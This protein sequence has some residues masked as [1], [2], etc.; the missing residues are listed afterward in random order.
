MGKKEEALKCFN[1]AIEV[2]KNLIRTHLAKGMILE[3]MGRKEDALESFKQYLKIDTPPSMSLKNPRHLKNTK[4]VL[5]RKA[6]LLFE[7]KRWMEA[8]VAFEELKRIHQEKWVDEKEAEA[9]SKLEEE[10]NEKRKAFLGVLKKSRK[11]FFV[12]RNIT[13]PPE[14]RWEI[15]MGGEECEGECVLSLEEKKKAVTFGSNWET[16]GKNAFKY[17]EHVGIAPQIKF[18]ASKAEEN[19]AL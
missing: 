19:K 11:V 17:W 6:M 12:M 16:L 3:E 10:T 14:I 1:K 13:L 5:E 7:L 18:L 9:L 8:V 15:A 2:D 4:Y